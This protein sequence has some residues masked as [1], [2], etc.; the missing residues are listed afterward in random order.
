M[1]NFEYNYS[2]CGDSPYDSLAE[3]RR[4]ECVDGWKQY[5]SMQAAYKVVGPY[6]YFKSYAFLCFAWNRDTHTMCVDSDCL[7]K[8]RTTN[9]Q[10]SRFMSDW[11]GIGFGLRH[12]QEAISAY[13]HDS[14]EYVIDGMYTAQYDVMTYMHIVVVEDLAY[15]IGE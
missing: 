8:S 1:T 13:E 9:R 15:Q 7:R 4:Y 11:I 6:V 5:R 14:D 2:R 12:L 3:Y 10:M